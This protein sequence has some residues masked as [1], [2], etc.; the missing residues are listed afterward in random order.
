MSR[1]RMQIHRQRATPPPLFSFFF[2]LVK[3]VSYHKKKSSRWRAVES[4]YYGCDYLLSDTPG[5]FC[6]QMASS[7]LLRQ[8]ARGGQSE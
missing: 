6:S 4:T 7:P 1:S 3:A 8:F 5:V 2:W